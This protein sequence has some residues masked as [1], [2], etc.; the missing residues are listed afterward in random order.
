MGGMMNTQERGKVE[1][2]VEICPGLIKAWMKGGRGGEV[3]GR[4][5]GR[6]RV[7]KW[8]GS[9]KGVEL[10]ESSLTNGLYFCFSDTQSR[11]FGQ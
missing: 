8:S 10:E 2:K 5:E 7:K 6:G 9:K 4:D 11:D 1:A 3:E